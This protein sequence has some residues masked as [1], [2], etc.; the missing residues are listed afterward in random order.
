MMAAPLV[1][2]M[3]A[4]ISSTGPRPSSERR[5]SPRATTRRTRAAYAILACVALT[6]STVQGQRDAASELFRAGQAAF[7]AGD[8]GASARAFEEAYRAEPSSATAYN[9]AL[10]WERASEPARAVD[11]LERTLA[12]DVDV[13][14]AAMRSDAEALLARLRPTIG[15]LVVDGPSGVSVDVSFHRA[16]VTPVRLALRPG[17]HLV[18]WRG[19]DGHAD[20]RFVEIVRG[21][22]HLDFGAV[23]P[24]ATTASSESPSELPSESSAVAASST[25][26]ARSTRVIPGIALVSTAIAFGAAGAGLGVATLRARDEYLDEGRRDRGDYDRAVRLRSATNVALA[27]TVVVGVVGVVLWIVRARRGSAERASNEVAT[28]AF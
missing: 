18:R 20:E 21:D 24:T 12:G 8:Y 16:R 22:V 17:R 11:A 5:A 4:P 26:P 1:A 13:L 7:E 23:G 10:A 9:A 25:S 14:E 27:A 28:W 3:A 15:Y 2:P 19:A 6:A